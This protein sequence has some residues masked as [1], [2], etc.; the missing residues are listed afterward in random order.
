MTT[1]QGRPFV[2]FEGLLA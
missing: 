1:I 2:K